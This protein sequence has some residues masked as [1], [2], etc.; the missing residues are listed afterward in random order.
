MIR[1]LDSKGKGNTRESE[2]VAHVSMPQGAWR[3]LFNELHSN[4][5]LG[6][7]VFSILEETSE[8]KKSKL[9]DQLYEQN[10]TSNRLTGPT[11][12]VINA[13]LAAYDPV[14]NLSMVSPNHRKELCQ[15][16]DITALSDWETMSNGERIV[17][18]NRMLVD[19]LRNFGFG[20]SASAR[21]LAKFC[22]WENMRLLWDK[23]SKPN[24]SE[25][26]SPWWQRFFESLDS[27]R[28][29]N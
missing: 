12:N 7:I 14:N 8:K 28:K 6:Q 20:Q 9:V 16:L 26:D 10:K 24:K 21:T 11:G 25:I 27:T 18:S 2:S 1:I 15:F 17:Q 5:K 22:Y 4:R 13:F 3:K 29:C 19:T 23:A